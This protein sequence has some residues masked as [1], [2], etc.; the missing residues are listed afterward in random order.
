MSLIEAVVLGV[1]Q[2]ATEFLPISSSGHLIV[3][4]YLF[5]WKNHSLVFDTTLHL[6]TSL[7][8]LV[9]FWK[10]LLDMVKNWREW[11]LKI[12]LGILPAGLL[13]FFL[14]DIFENYFR[15][16]NFVILFL[17]LGS[18]LM[19]GAEKISVEEPSEEITPL[20]SLKI[21]LF[22]ALALFPGV[23]RSGSTI[24]GGML[25]SLSREKAARFSF[26]LSIPLVW[27]AGLYEFTQISFSTSLQIDSLTLL[28]GALTSFVTGF[29][30]IKYLMKFLKKNSLYL[31][32]VYRFVLVILLL[33]LFVVRT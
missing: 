30:C 12:L 11:W 3:V 2:G 22:Q 31:F 19:L 14:N 6:G 29:L 7:A 26:L 21:G 28:L 18:L 25:S 8:L 9:Y 10:D 16:I 27:A 23:S 24:S 17:V 32:I 15:N 33:F 20:K 5:G 13:G 1:V 4:P